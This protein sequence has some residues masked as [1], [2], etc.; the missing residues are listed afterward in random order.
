MKPSYDELAQAFKDAMGCLDYCGWGDSYERSCAR[1]SGD[2]SRLEGVLQNLEEA[3]QA[4]AQ[5]EEVK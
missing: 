1:E 4:A 5:S 3:E 2:M